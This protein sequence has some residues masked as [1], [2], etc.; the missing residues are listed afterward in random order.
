MKN[1][2]PVGQPTW[3]KKRSETHKYTPYI[4]W[5]QTYHK[6]PEGS[7]RDSKSFHEKL[8]DIGQDMRRKYG[9]EMAKDT[10]ERILK[11][12]GPDRGN[13]G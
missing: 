3:R 9:K 2:D 4:S 6:V 13:R 10:L 1:V 12:I 5:V 8:V 7:P 11:R